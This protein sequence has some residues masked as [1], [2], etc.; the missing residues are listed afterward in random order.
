MFDAH[1]RDGDLHKAEPFLDTFH[2]FVLAQCGQP[3]CNGLVQ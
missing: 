2:P 3:L 1:I